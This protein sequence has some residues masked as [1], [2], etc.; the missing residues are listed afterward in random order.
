[1]LVIQL[2]FK[3]AFSW[4]QASLHFSSCLSFAPQNKKPKN[5]PQQDQTNLLVITN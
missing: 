4:S 1:M 2:R 3:E 5:Q